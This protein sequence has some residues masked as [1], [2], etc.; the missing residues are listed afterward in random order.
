[1]VATGSRVPN[2]RPFVGQ[3]DNTAGWL[4]EP[5]RGTVLEQNGQA[6]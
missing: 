2:S 1:M 5:T 6:V 4:R 3:D